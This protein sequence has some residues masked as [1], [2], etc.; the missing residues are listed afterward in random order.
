MGSENGRRNRR[1]YNVSVSSSKL[2]PFTASHR[3]GLS[4]RG[5]YEMTKLENAEIEDE[6]YRIEARLERGSI[7][8]HKIL[9]DKARNVKTA[10]EVADRICHDMKLKQKKAEQQTLNQYVQRYV[11]KHK[12]VKEIKEEIKMINDNQ[13]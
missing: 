13:R 12:K 11:E 7:N 2:R 4:I 10:N 8:H 5:S 6:L 1:T 3:M 9:L